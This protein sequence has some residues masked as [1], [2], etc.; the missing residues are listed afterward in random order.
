VHDNSLKAIA[1]TTQQNTSFLYSCPRYP[2]HTTTTLPV[3]PFLL[4]LYMATCI[5]SSRPRFTPPHTRTQNDPPTKIL[6]TGGSA[7]EEK[8]VCGGGRE[9]M[10]IVD[11]INTRTNALQKTG[12][13]RG[14]YWTSHFY[15]SHIITH[16]PFPPY[17]AVRICT[18]MALSPR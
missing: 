5:I 4:P 3:C 12:G 15:C 17:V 9:D 14:H 13:A 10:E 6:S 11:V 18:G 7:K 1:I 8:C 2:L 16:P